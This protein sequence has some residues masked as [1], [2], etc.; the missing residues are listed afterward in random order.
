MLGVPF[1]T[2]VSSDVPG[3]IEFVGKFLLYDASKRV[4]AKQ[5]FLQLRQVL[6]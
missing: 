5:V 1:D 3:A 4:T 2:L 6:V